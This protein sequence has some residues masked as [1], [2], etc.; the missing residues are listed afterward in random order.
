MTANVDVIIPGLFQL[1][2]NELEQGFVENRLA[3]LNHILRY[4]SKHPEIQFDF[5]P[6]L[7]DSLGLA[8]VSC[9]PF[10]SAFDARQPDRTALLCEAVHLKPDMRHAYVVPLDTSE[11]TENQINIII[12]DLSEY[13]KVDFN[14]E[15]HQDRLWI[16][17]ALRC[18]APLHLPHILSVIGRKVDPYIKQSKENLAWYQLINEVQMFMHSHE[19]N[20]QRIRDGQLAIN[21]L[22]CWGAGQLQ[23]WPDSN[24]QCFCDDPLSMALLTKHGL[25]VHGLSDVSRAGMADHNICIDLSLLEALKR[26]GDEELAL[27][28]ENIE[29]NLL[30][31][32]LNSVRAGKLRL[33]LRTGHESL[34]HIHR[35]SPLRFWRKQASLSGMM[36]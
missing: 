7:A 12:S 4:S 36:E 3:A 19:V 17:R 29:V 24:I 2:L 11:E 21:S 18:T 23:E 10:A 20:Q 30:R 8:S 5:E 14:L 6:L 9:L 32:L 35:F 26:P 22:W 27:I 16:M 25:K 13:F 15:N 28:I 34:Y 1:P 33:R 31:P